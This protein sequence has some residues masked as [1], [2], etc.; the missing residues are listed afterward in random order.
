MLLQMWCLSGFWEFLKLTHLST[1]GTYFMG[2]IPLTHRL[3][4]LVG[5]AAQNPP[6]IQMKKIGHLTSILWGMASVEVFLI[7]LFAVEYKFPDFVKELAAA[8]TS[9][10]GDGTADASQFINV[11]SILGP[12]FY[13]LIG[14]SIVAGLLQ[15]YL[16]IW[17]M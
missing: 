14:Y 13:V 5:F 17:H 11:N 2:P 3:L 10:I 7:G 9:G 4:H 15:Y 1:K 6:K 8:G 12:G 16:R